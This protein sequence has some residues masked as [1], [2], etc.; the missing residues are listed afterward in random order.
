[1]PETPLGFI[2]GKVTIEGLPPAPT[3]LQIRIS[4]GADGGGHGAE[5][6]VPPN[7]SGSDFAMPLAPGDYSVF[8]QFGSAQTPPQKA[9]V[10]NGKASPV[11]FAFGK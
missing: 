5:V 4:A 8:A 6:F 1:M 2:T 11:N 7:P 10:A 3:G 9:T